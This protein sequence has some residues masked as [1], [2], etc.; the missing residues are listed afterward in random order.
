[1]F[2]E[3]EFPYLDGDGFQAV[4]LPYGKNERISMCIF[5]PDAGKTPDSFYGKLDS[6]QWD[7]WMS[8][9]RD[10]EGAVG[11]PRFKFEY[12]ASLND[13]LKTLGMEIAFDNRA[14]DF[15]SMRP[16][17]PRLYIGEVKH[18]SFVE[19]D[20]RGT[21]AAAATSV[22]IK[23]ESAPMDWFSMTAD[24]PFFF[25]IVDNKTGSILFMGSVTDPLLFNANNCI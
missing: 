6:A 17:P 13:V 9:F 22:E 25:S 4:A 15:S 20:E 21:E 8:S 11:I 1:M 23:E 10:S 2:Q 16:T 14:A 12:E 18:K 24:R 3:G 7:S 19:V 5:L